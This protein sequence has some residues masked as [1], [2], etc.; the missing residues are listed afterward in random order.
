LSQQPEGPLQITRLAG[1]AIAREGHVNPKGLPVKKFPLRFRY[2]WSLVAAACGGLSL[3]AQAQVMSTEPVRTAQAS[4]PVSRADSYTTTDGYSLLPYT[5]RGYVGI[6]LGQTEFKTGCGNVAYGC[7]D[8][9]VGVRCTPA[10][11]ST[12]GW[13]WSSATPTPAA[14]NVP[15]A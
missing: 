3:A 7:G 6:N 4:A 5:R 9:D 8:S 12:N 15:V 2:A 1:T 11:C 14:P 13:A 10:V